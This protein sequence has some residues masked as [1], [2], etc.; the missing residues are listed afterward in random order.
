[1]YKL[2]NGH[3]QITEAMNWKGPDGF[4]QSFAVAISETKSGAPVLVLLL[5]PEK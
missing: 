3:V 5:T 1:M 4:L 2:S